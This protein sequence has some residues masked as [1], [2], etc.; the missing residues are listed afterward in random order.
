MELACA[1]LL[2]AGCQKEQAT[3]VIADGVTAH[4]VVKHLPAWRIF[5]DGPR[6]WCH[7]MGGNCAMDVVIRPPHVSS[8]NSVFAALFSGN[9][10]AIKS[11]FS[12]NHTVLV[13][14]VSVSEVDSV[15][16][17]TYDASAR[18]DTLAKIRFILIG[19]N[20][21]PVSVYPLK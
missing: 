17:G 14:Y 6:R 4:G 5:T 12:V 2:L 9:K 13:N 19:P 21:N 15:I 16:A 3:P 1:A 20:L 7:S 10:S 11:T 18:E 8:M